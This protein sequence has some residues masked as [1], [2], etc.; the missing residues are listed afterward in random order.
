MLSLAESGANIGNAAEQ[1]ASALSANLANAQQ[2]L[3]PNT[4]SNV[5]GNLTNTTN[6]MNTNAQTRMGL[7]AAQAYTGAFSNNATTNSGYANPLG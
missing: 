7:K 6:Q 3:G 4:L 5:F 1:T 2:N